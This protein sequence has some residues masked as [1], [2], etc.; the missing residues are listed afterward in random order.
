MVANDSN[1][2]VTEVFSSMFEKSVLG[3][4]LIKKRCYWHK[5]VPAEEIIWHMQNKEFGYVDVVQGS[6]RGKRYHI[7][8]I[9][10]PDY[11]MLMSTTYG[12]LE[13]LEGSDTHWRYKGVGGELVTKKLKYREFFGNH[14]NYRHQVDDNNNQCHSPI[15]VDRTWAKNYWTNRCHA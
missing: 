15:S 13:H 14:F 4:A 1:L 9:K 10:E 8:D 7:M 3:L 12:T 5:G 2:C 11:V 6:I